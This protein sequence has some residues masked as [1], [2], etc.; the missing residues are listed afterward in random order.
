[1]LGPQWTHRA[2]WSSWIISHVYNQTPSRPRCLVILLGRGRRGAAG[3]P[4]Q[5]S[6][7]IAASRRAVSSPSISYPRIGDHCL[8]QGSCLVMTMPSRS[9]INGTS[10]GKGIFGTDCRSWDHRLQI[11]RIALDTKAYDHRRTEK[12]IYVWKA[13]D[14]GDH[15]DTK[16]VQPSWT[17]RDQN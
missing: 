8:C 7:R 2:L 16:R 15:D 12:Q 1:M 11:I 10:F 6:A 9:S 5:G 13:E 4:G 17:Q 14:V 3:R